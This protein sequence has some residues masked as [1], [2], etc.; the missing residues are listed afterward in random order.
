[1]GLFKKEKSI[2]RPDLRSA[3]RKDSGIIK[4][5]EGKFN[6][7][8]REKIVKE[9]FGPK[10]GKEISK[11]D[12]KKAIRVLERKRSATSGIKESEKIDDKIKYLKQIAGKGF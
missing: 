9:V 3:L 4:G 7:G 8:D 12:F 11:D 1:M 2:S 6:Y 5:G 10:Y